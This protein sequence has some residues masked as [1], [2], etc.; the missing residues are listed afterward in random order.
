MSYWR[1]CPDLTKP[2]NLLQGHPL[3]LKNL[4]TVFNQKY[5]QLPLSYPKYRWVK[6]DRPNSLTRAISVSETMGSR[7][8]LSSS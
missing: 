4:S 1:T 2:I 6:F 8:T 7:I 3:T 5:C